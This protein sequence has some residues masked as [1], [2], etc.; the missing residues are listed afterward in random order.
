M[1]LA[2]SPGGVA[3]PTD[4]G[5]WGTPVK[6]TP[7]KLAAD[8]WHG[9]L[10]PISPLS[11]PC[12]VPHALPLCPPAD[13]CKAPEEP[14]AP[15][16]WVSAE[17]LIFFVKHGPN[18]SPQVVASSPT[19]TAPTSVISGGRDIDYGTFSG[20]R[21]VT[22]RWLNNDE[23]VGLEG[24]AFYLWRNDVSDAG[25]PTPGT[26]G[27]VL[28]RPFAV[29]GLGTVTAPFVI[30]GSLNGGFTVNGSSRLY[31]SDNY[32]LFN[33]TKSS[34]GRTDFLVGGRY[35]ELDE[36]Q[37]V[38]T[39]STPVGANLASFNGLTARLG[40]P[41]AVTD[42][43]DTVTRFAGGT[44]GLRSEYNLGRVML[45]AIGKVSLGNSH[46]VYFING[47]T[48]LLTPAGV[49][50]VPGGLLTGNSN[51]GRFTHDA[52]AVIP[53]VNVSLSYDVTKW[54]QVT[55]GYNFLYIDKVARPGAVLSQTVAPSVGLP[56]AATPRLPGDV[57]GSS[58]YAHGANVGVVLRY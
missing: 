38:N 14:E 41:L 7:G 6:V 42:Q 24:S 54:L 40:S 30:P 12:D 27:A 5:S 43:V 55:G 15:R 3:L 32:L 49:A 52:F 2:Q 11:P 51:V 53:E 17:Y 22:G 23:T 58:F 31:S 56:T 34:L 29:P 35:L 47:A 45:T 26:A 10:T 46:E 50:A 28:A 16:T 8:P 48:S 19:G 18:P 13:N 44:I 39:L 57:T 37:G 20:L 4:A 33:L 1:G 25:F 9:P 21:V 36:C